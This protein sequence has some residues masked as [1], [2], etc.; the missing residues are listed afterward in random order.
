MGASR[1]GVE[2]CVHLVRR[3]VPRDNR[4]R[5][6]L[7]SRRDQ[8]SASQPEGSKLPVGLKKCRPL[9]VFVICVNNIW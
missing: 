4:P 1:A 8:G 6:A 9:R 3:R 2:V 5:I 7:T